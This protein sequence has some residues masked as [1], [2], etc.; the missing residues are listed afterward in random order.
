[1]VDPSSVPRRWADRSV[2][3]ALVPLLP[4][5][6]RS[7]FHGEPVSPELS[8]EDEAVL[9]RAA[10]GTA[11]SEIASELGI[12]PRSVYR[13]LA[14]LRRRFGAP[15]TSELVAALARRGF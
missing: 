2:L 5:E 8:V 13:R 9:R 4:K 14:K 3:V 10:R 1:M 7:L 12:S 15:T 11:P 6:A